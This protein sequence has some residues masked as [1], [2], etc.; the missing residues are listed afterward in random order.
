M[1]LPPFLAGAALLFWGFESG[2]LAVAVPLAAA[3]EAPR[4]VRARFA[5]EPADYARV[6]DLCT[7]FFVGLAV[8][9]AADRGVA[10]RS[11]TRA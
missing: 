1:S 2:N 10:H 4:W 5:L 6:A 8:V 9:M 11:A 7:I 3:L